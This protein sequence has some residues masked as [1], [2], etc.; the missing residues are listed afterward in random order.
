M[1]ETLPQKIFGME[2]GTVIYGAGKGILRSF[3][4][5]QFC[6]EPH[7]NHSANEILYF[8]DLDYEGIGIYE[9]LA[10]L[11]SGSMEEA[12]NAG[13]AGDKSTGLAP[14][15]LSGCAGKSAKPH[16][17]ALLAGA[18]EELPNL[19]EKRHEIRPFIQA[20]EKM[21]EKA[22]KFG[23]DFLP[24]MS[25]NQNHKLSGKF[26]RYF[27][28]QTKQAMERILLENRYIPQEIV[29]ITDY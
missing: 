25:E 9:R 10:D 24:Q 27:N 11:F 15:V 28:H 17:D 1:A 22:L 12:A 2:I 26:F 8:G 16:P 14:E 7:I 13:W 18:G 21:I 3:E 5:F 29:T 6:V 19:T 20:Y 23:T 4:D